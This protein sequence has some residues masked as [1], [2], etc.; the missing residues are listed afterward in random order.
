MRIA[1]GDFSGILSAQIINSPLHHF[2]QGLSHYGWGFG[3]A[4]ASF[5]ER[6]DFG[7]G[8]P[9]SAADDG[10]GVSHS[11]AWRSGGAGDESGNRFLAMFTDPISGFLFSGTAD[12]TDHDDAVCIGIV[13]EHFD[14]VEVRGAMDGIAADADACG[15]AHV[16]ASELPDGFV[17]QSAAS[18]DNADVT[19]FVDVTRSDSDAAAAVRIFA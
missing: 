7:F 19:L 18:R 2:Q 3:D 5:A 17:G 4:D 8:G 9:F 1:L 15:L 10:A 11:A 12:F 6:F 13:I 16:A 14:H